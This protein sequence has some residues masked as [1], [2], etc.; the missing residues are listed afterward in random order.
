MCLPNH[1]RYRRRR[2]HR[3][4]HR[5]IFNLMALSDPAVV[6]LFHVTFSFRPTT[7]KVFL[8]VVSYLRY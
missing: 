1:H 8:S 6:D 3:H 5:H 2:G 7:N 4:H